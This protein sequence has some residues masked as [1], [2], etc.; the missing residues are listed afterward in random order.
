MYFSQHGGR[1]VVAFTADAACATVDHFAGRPVLHFDEAQHRFPPATHELF[2]A[3]GY[4]QRNGVRRGVVEQARALGH[5]LPSFVHYSAVVARSAPI[6]ANCMLSELAA[7]S[8][9]ASVGDGVVIDP[10]PALQRRRRCARSRTPP[11]KIVHLTSD[12]K[13]VP[14]VQSLFELAFPGP[15]PLPAGQGA[16]W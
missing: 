14:L 3:V 12:K 1:E 8:L 5:T 7:V 16:A 6:G 15:E 11:M 10:R 2:V 4:A 9:F 13:F